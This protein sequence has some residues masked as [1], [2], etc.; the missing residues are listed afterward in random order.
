M[1]ASKDS[2]LSSLRVA[3]VQGQ[4]DSWKYLRRQ[5]LRA[6][7]QFSAVAPTPGKN[8]AWYEVY[9]MLSSVPET[10]VLFLPDSAILQVHCLSYLEQSYLLSAGQDLWI[11]QTEQ[12]PGSAYL[13][14]M[15]ARMFPGYVH[16][17]A[18]LGRKSML[19]PNLQVF[20]SLPE[21]PPENFLSL[22]ALKRPDLA[23]MDLYGRLFGEVGIS[24]AV[25]SCRTINNIAEI[26]ISSTIGLSAD[27]RTPMVLLP[28]KEKN[29]FPLIDFL[30]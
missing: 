11:A 12:P 27:F 4:D 19:L 18:F 26:R 17:Q 15:Q 6:G 13:K 24:A 8:N 21:A 25:E 22:C 14:A 3:T 10:F 23:K 5:V 1:N 20:E 29:H 9:S 16:P 2:V 7:L 30:K 28:T